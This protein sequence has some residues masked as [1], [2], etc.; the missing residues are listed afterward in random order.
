MSHLTVVAFAVLGLTAGAFAGAWYVESVDT[1]GAVGLYT[2]MALDNS[3]NAHIS[4]R[5]NTICCLKYAK[6]DG[7]SW[8]V[9]AVDITGGGDAFYT[10]IAVDTSDN[11]RISYYDDSNDDLKYAYHDGS[12]WHIEV[13]DTTDDVGQYSSIALDISDNPHISYLDVTNTDL[14][15]AYHDGS[16]W[17][18]ESV[19]TTAEAGSH[20]SI[21]LDASGNPHISYFGSYPNHYLN[22][23]YYDGSSWQIES[24]DTTGYVGYYTSICLDSSD[25]P[26]ISYYDYTNGDLKYAYYDGSSWQLESIDT[27]GVVGI[28]T[29]IALDASDKPHISYYDGTNDDLKY[30]FSDGPIWRREKVDTVGY[31]GRF[32]SIALDVLDNPHIT[33]YDSN[34]RDLKYAWYNT[35]PARF[36]LLSPGDG[37]TVGDVPTFDW[38]DALD[39]QHVTYD[40][41]Y[42][43]NADFK[44]HKEIKGLTDSTY[45]F[46]EGLLADGKTYYWKV[47]A[48]DGHGKRWSGPDDYWSF[49]VDY[50][51][52]IRVTS[53]SA[54]SAAEGIE[55]SWECTDEVAGFNL[56]RSVGSGS[57]KAVTS[58]DR[59]NGELITGKSPYS[60]LDAAVDEGAA[61]SYWL[62]AIDVGGS[63]ETFG[64][65]DCT[66]NGALPTTYAL[67]QS[68]PNPA[69]G[70]AKIAFDLPE[71]A[72]VIL[73]VYDISGRKVTT[74]VNETLTVGTHERTVS[75]LAP[76]AYVYKLNAGSFS[77]ARKMV[78]VD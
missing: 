56:Y 40:L 61:Y 11:P 36:N 76:G 29:S 59:L 8:Q 20:T 75:G 78:I 3:G 53:F 9:N 44:P 72:K 55:V 37:D 67:Y 10:S 22:Y 32:T 77:A 70:T 48:S 25:N 21:A 69:T 7:S 4:Y 42:S 54:A 24:V 45:T 62:E 66:W 14:K 52:D 12:S 57:G 60:Y 19:D 30:A 46:D 39:A 64:P 68:R 34:N 41:W 5:D 6:Y 28:N 73:V 18:I 51:L 43:V 33:Y 58:R 23:A 38:E 26:H 65:V 47:R 27:E 31:V 50:E 17:Q 1:S 71:N 2:S 15:Y 13:V 74:L 35:P 49:T 63:S 16:S